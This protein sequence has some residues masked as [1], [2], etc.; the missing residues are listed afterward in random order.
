MRPAATDHS[1]APEEVDAVRDD[2]RAHL[3]V[4][5]QRGLIVAAG[6]QDPR[7]GGV[8]IARGARDELEAHLAADPYVTHGLVEVDITPFAA[9]TLA[10]ALSA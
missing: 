7:T 10:P 1:A 4:A 9:V 5:V 8:I 6:P 3:R 2:H